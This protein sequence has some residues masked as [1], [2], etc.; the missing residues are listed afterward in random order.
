MRS[1]RGYVAA[2]MEDIVAVHTSHL[3]DRSVEPW[4]CS[5]CGYRLTD[6]RVAEPCRFQDSVSAASI[7]QPKVEPAIDYFVINRGFA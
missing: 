1:Q 7:P 3:W 6:A 4:I 5:G 2:N